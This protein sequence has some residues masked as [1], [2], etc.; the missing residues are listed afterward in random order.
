M[1]P[2]RA[3]MQGG[4]AQGSYSCCCRPAC[5]GHSMKSTLWQQAVQQGQGEGRQARKQPRQRT[6]LK[7][8]VPDGGSQ[9]PVQASSQ[10]A[11]ELAFAGD[12]G[13]WRHRCMGTAPQ[14]VAGQAEVLPLLRRHCMV[15]V[16]AGK[17]APQQVTAETCKP[18]ASWAHARPQAQQVAFVCKEEFSISGLHGRKGS[19]GRAAAET[20]MACIPANCKGCQACKGQEQAAA[21][22]TCTTG[23][24]VH[25]LKTCCIA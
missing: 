1:H 2:M 14:A 20:T 13:L 22:S 18:S 23:A 4:N 25:Q 17:Y 16:E 21:C 11:L 24:Q 8:E 3:P 12:D 19:P 5:S 6:S 7:P 15:W 9:P 10:H